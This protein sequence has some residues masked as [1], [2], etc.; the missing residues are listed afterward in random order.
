[1]TLPAVYDRD[2]IKR[3][4]KEMDDMFSSLFESRE[5]EDV[6]WSM[7]APLTDIEDKGDE[8]VLTADLPGMKKEDI[9]ISVDED[10]VSLKAER[11]NR[12]EQKE[13]DYYFFE[14]TYSGFRRSFALPHKVNPEK[15]SASY[16]NGLLKVRMEKSAKEME[17]RKKVRIE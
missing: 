14:R 10:T 3:L 16:E 13:N 12:Q 8:I 5:K 6:G 4:Q 9:E 11:K 2:E 17:S 7:R 1:M 15:V